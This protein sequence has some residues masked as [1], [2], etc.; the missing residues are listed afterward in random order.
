MK[1]KGETINRKF[2]KLD[3]KKEELQ[4]KKITKNKI[5]RQKTDS[6]QYL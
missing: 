3:Y 1:A 5:K 2:D 4:V 6:E